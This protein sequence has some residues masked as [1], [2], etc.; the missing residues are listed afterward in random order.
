MCL[1]AVILLRELTMTL[2]IAKEQHSLENS[3][4]LAVFEDFGRGCSV[5][6]SQ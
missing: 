1:Y 4:T 6:D 2:V 5:Q 3:N